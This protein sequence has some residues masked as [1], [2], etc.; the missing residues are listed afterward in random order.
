MTGEI[1]FATLVSIV[2]LI[3]AAIAI[4][5]V[6]Y[7]KGKFD[8]S[9]KPLIEANI[10]ERLTKLETKTDLFWK[11]VEQ[12]V[13]SMLKSPTHTDKDV[14]LDKLAERSLTIN[15]AERLRAILRDEIQTDKERAIAYILILSRLEQ[16]IYELRRGETPYLH[17]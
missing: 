15:D 17:I 5:T 9:I 13:G 3:S 7:N 10:P 11:V 4:Y 6:V 8:Q 1:T 12:S 16:I 2:A 14:L